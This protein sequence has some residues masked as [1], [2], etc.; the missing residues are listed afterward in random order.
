[1][2]D[3][4]GAGRW[5]ATAFVALGFIPLAVYLIKVT[6]RVLKKFYDAIFPGPPVK[7][8]AMTDLVVPRI[9]MYH[10]MQ[11]ALR[12]HDKEHLEECV[13]YWTEYGIEEIRGINPDLPGPVKIPG[14]YLAGDAGK[15][16]FD[17]GTGTEK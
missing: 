1:M 9:N 4:G 3:S 5:F 6:C 15:R 17:S 14:L 13:R 8:Y 12:A 16:K 2:L 10:T 7:P 11:A